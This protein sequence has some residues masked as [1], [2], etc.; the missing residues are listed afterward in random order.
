MTDPLAPVFA[1]TAPAGVLS[2]P[3]ALPAQRALDG[4][5]TAGWEA[6]DLDLTGV[7]DKTGLMTACATAM[8]FP[9][10]FGANWDALADCL[11]DLEWWPASRGR[12]LLVR[13]WQEYAAARPEEW[14]TLQEIFADAAA[15]WRETETGLA[16]VMVLA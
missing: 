3:A 7:S 16:V 6:V 15:S 9:D 13:N 10:R 12:L 4:A 1:G 5:R 2:W 11:G 8:R 14:N